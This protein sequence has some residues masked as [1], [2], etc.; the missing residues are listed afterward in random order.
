M[1]KIT[2]ALEEYRFFISVV[3]Q[4]AKTTINNYMNDLKKYVDFLSK[5]N[6]FD[7]EKID[8]GLIEQFIY[9]ESNQKKDTSINRIIV[10]LRNFHNFISSQDESIANPT[11]FLKLRKIGRKLPKPIN[12][13]DTEAILS[14]SELNK[15]KEVYHHCILEILYGC[16]LRVSECCN[17]KMNQL[18]LTEGIIKVVGKGDKERI[19][20]INEYAEKT[21]SYYLTEIRSK[22]NSKKLSNVFVNQLGNVLTRQYVHTMIKKY[23][24]EIG[25]NPSI[26]AHTFR[27]SFAT[28]LLENGADLRVVQELLGHSDISTT[29][30]YTHVQKDRIKQIYLNAHP[31][32][33]K[34]NIK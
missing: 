28:D 25:I 10:S 20:P 18:H 16:G 19:V 12:K 9:E 33:K 2:E 13:M 1:M 4:K 24:H 23:V 7:M 6:I 31:Q 14:H 27:H 26:S 29:Q 17:L 5:N 22:W 11:I 8:Y 15:D 34:S 21:I 30:I 32:N 3:D